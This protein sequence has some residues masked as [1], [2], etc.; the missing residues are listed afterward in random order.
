[1]KKQPPSP[2]PAP[3]AKAA[4]VPA[5]HGRFGQPAA[6]GPAEATR[7]YCGLDA[8]LPADDAEADRRA[9]SA[10]PDPR[11]AGGDRFDLQNEQTSP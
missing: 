2:P 5:D 6:S 9:A 1:M 3:P 4:P 11:Y 8:D 10:R 7:E